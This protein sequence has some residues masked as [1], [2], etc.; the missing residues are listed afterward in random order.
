MFGK[1][2]NELDAHI[3]KLDRLVESSWSITNNYDAQS[4]KEVFD[5]KLIGM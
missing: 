2:Y 1:N 5:L 3:S 4:W